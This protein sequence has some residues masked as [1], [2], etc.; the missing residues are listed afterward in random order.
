MDMEKLFDER[1]QNVCTHYLQNLT[2][3]ERGV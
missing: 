2:F 3:S 1:V